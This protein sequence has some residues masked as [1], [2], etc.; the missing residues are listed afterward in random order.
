MIYHRSVTADSSL[1]LTTTTYSS[2]SEPQNRARIIR[3]III[4][5]S[6]KIIGIFHKV[7][8][9]ERSLVSELLTNPTPPQIPTYFEHHATTPSV[10]PFLYYSRSPFVD[11]W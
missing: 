5:T 6:T 2:S 9:I 1:L 8:G 3:I 4:I 7:P 10:R 11:P